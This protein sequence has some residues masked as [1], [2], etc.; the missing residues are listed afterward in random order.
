[1]GGAMNRDQVLAALRTHK[2]FLAQRF[3]ISE[4]ALFGSFARDQADDRS[5]VDVLVTFVSPPD[6]KR[7]F[8]AQAYLEDIF[9][10][11]VDLAINADV[12]AEIRP[13]VEREA[14]DA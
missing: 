13:Y 5:D 14:V 9:G 1:M 12:R 2:A 8:G 11:P 7:Y 6:W 3:G 10:R 4:I